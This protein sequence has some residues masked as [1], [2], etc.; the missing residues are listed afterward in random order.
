[1]IA[2]F[3]SG[4]SKDTPVPPELALNKFSTAAGNMMWRV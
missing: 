4:R 3:H 2:L 1:M